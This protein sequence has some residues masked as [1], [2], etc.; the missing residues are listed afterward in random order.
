MC[1]DFSAVK[2]GQGAVF[3]FEQQADFG[4]AQNHALGTLRAQI[5]NHIQIISLGFGFK[6]AEA[7]FIENHAVD[8]RLLCF[9][10]HQSAHALLLHAAAVETVAHGELGAEQTHRSQALRFHGFGGGINQMQQRHL[11]GGLNF[12]GHF[13]HG[14][15]GQQQHIGA[16]ALE[17]LRALAQAGGRCRPIAG[18]LQRHNLLEI[19]AVQHN[20]GAA[21]AAQAPVDFTVDGLVIHNRAFG[22][23][24][25]D[26]ADG[27][28]RFLGV[29]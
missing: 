14:V 19:H 29:L 20:I 21:V 10:R 13:V 3:G 22:A 6:A 18:F 15:G 24:A 12:I 7:Q 28:H 16:D 4:A 2:Q 9:R 27:F 17:L 23:H 25:A 5:F 26:N 1:V 11:H 8:F